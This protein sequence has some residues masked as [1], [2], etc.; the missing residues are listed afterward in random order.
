MPAQQPNAGQ[1]PGPKS[2]ASPTAKPMSAATRNSLV[3]RELIEAKRR[4][5]QRIW[6]AKYQHLRRAIEL[7]PGGFVVDQPYG[8]HWGVR[9]NPTGFKIHAPARLVNN[10][11][12]QQVE[13]A[14]GQFELDPTNLP[15]LTK[16]SS[17]SL[18]FD[19]M[20]ALK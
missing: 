10:L 14:T 8:R 13:Q 6:E 4:S 7:D 12:R 3:L 16:L 17:V 19:L 20:R 9:H 11:P 5:D 18:L 1:T 15:D 2:T